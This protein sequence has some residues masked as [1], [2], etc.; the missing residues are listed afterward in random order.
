MFK[1]HEP[2][3][4]LINKIV[5]SNKLNE[6]KWIFHSRPDGRHSTTEGKLYMIGISA[7]RNS[8][9]SELGKPGREVI[10]SKDRS[11]LKF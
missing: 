8:S 6:S 7:Y 1:Y 11:L 9:F 10:E 3:I 2:M 5:N 4:R